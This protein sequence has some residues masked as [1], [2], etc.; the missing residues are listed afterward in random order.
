MGFPFAP[1]FSI[2]IQVYL[3]FVIFIGRLDK[4][5]IFIIFVELR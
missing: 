2:N 1:P 4:N 3:S 5:L